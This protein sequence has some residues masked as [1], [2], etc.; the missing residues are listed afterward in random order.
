MAQLSPEEGKLSGK[1]TLDGLC[2]L[3]KVKAKFLTK[4]KSNR[5][6]RRFGQS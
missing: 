4:N 2:L 6:I 5:V 1:D 3:Q